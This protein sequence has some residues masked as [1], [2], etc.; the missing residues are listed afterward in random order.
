MTRIRCHGQPHPITH[1]V[2]GLCRDCRRRTDPEKPGD[3]WRESLAKI[4]PAQI[5]EHDKA[6]HWTC[7]ARVE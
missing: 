6:G 2:I 1:A 4:D 3:E 5:S 7:K